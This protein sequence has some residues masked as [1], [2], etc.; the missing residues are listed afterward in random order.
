MNEITRELQVS[1]Y[2]H[3]QFGKE[4][5]I[6]LQKRLQTLIGNIEVAHTNMQNISQHVEDAMT[7]A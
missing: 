1:S 5:W 7:A 2:Q 6:T 4:Q 3:R